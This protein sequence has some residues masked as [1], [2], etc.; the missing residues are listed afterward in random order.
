MRKRKQSVL[1]VFIN[2]VSLLLLFLLLHQRLLFFS[3]PWLN[4]FS[5]SVILWTL[6]VWK[7]LTRLV[8]HYACWMLQVIQSVLF[9]IFYG[10][11]RRLNNFLLAH[12]SHIYAV[13]DIYLKAT[14]FFSETEYK[15]NDLGS[16]HWQYLSRFLLDCTFS[17]V[18]M[19]NMHTAQWFQGKIYLLSRSITNNTWQ[20]YQGNRIY[21]LRCHHDVKKSFLFG[22]STH[23][24]LSGTWKM[25]AFLHY[26]NY[27]CPE[28][29]TLSAK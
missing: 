27:L 29:Q 7:L 5:P 28:N 26:N 17:F 14:D 13:I 10:C 12:C 8:L 20:C 11:V 22:T 19:L 25:N 15:L 9:I 1:V 16:W 18:K 23:P 4:L 6:Y 2:V 21:Y 24:I 3:L